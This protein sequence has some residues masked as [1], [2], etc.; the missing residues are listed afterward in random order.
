VEIHGH[1]HAGYSFLSSQQSIAGQLAS[2]EQVAIETDFGRLDVVQG[3]AGV[4][5]YEE[6][7]ARSMEVEIFGVKVPVCSIEDLKAMKHAGAERAI[8]PTS[9]IWTLPAGRGELDAGVP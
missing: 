2:G 1:V 5:A 8:W 4:P 3:L 6:L 9:R 7:H